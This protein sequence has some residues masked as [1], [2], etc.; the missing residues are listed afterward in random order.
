MLVYY[1]FMFWLGSLYYKIISPDTT[2]LALESSLSRFSIFWKVLFVSS[3]LMVVVE[4][5]SELFEKNKNR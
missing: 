3:L 5:H 2:F 1:L 4:F